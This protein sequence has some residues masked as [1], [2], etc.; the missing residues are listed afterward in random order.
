MLCPVCNKIPL[1]GRKS[2]AKTCSTKCRS[3]LSRQRKKQQ[4]D[5]SQQ[6]VKRTAGTGIAATQRQLRSR[7]SDTV[8]WEQLI[9]VATE[10]IVEAVR[11]HGISA[12]PRPM[13]A[14]RVDMRAQVTAQA[15]KLAVGY[16]LVLPARHTGDPP[17]WSPR[18]SRT[19]NAAWYLLTPFEYPDDIRLGDG[20]WY[21]IVWID[22]AGQR[23]RLQPAEPVPGLCYC[24]GPMQLADKAS[25]S[26]PVAACGM[27][28]QD[29][30]DTPKPTNTCPPTLAQEQSSPAGAC[31]IPRQGAQDISPRPANTDPSTVPAEQ[32]SPAAACE[33]PPQG[34]QDI[35]ANPT[36]QDPSTVAPE[37]TTPSVTIETAAMPAPQPVITPFAPPEPRDDI[38]AL[39]SEFA[40]ASELDRE[41]ALRLGNTGETE[42]P[43][44]SLVFMVPPPPTTAPPKSWIRL[45]MSHPQ[46]SG[47]ESAMLTTF[48]MSPE[49]MI[50][51]RYEERLY[52]AKAN[53]LDLPREPVTLI[54][55][56]ARRNL[57]ELF[58]DRVFPPRF[59]VLCNEVFDYARQHGVEVLAHLPVPPALLPSAERQWIET[60]I[61]NLPMRTYMNYVCA[62]QDALLHR[63][64]VPVEP[65]VPLSA[66][67]RKQIQKIL[68]DLRAV[69]YFRDCVAR[70]APIRS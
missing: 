52:D 27:P 46:L 68:G 44:G 7:S 21:R 17:K 13:D 60:A 9:S 31:E 49:L 19:S 10:R 30:Q 2:T 18:R 3:A 20:C 70:S 41:R 33:I 64:A 38:E 36:N 50:Q 37:Q 48:I 28:A 40:R 32:S 29:A 35:P 14:M 66:K 12:A 61:T 5:T 51:I 63:Q 54:R 62:W 4:R 11:T 39:A 26:S 1:T 55:Q 59:W 25:T 8:N 58:R 24:V 69:M 67:E 43:P 53:G 22:A 16:R 15:P 6:A 65:S 56:E 23:I 34:A 47:D 45:L 57:H 42:I